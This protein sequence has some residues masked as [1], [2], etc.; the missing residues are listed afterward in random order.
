MTKL[1]LIISS[2]ILGGVV[3]AYTYILQ[4]PSPSSSPIKIPVF[5]QKEVIG[6]LPYWLL[7]RAQ[8]DYSQDITTL[9]YFALRTNSDGS[10]LKLSSANQ[11]EPGYH[12]LY[13]GKVDTFLQNAKTKGLKLSL[14]LDSGD[15][16]AIQG[17][18][19]TP[20]AN[21]KRLITDTL[22]I[23]QKY[24]FSDLNLDIEYTSQ[25]SPQMRSNFAEFIK[26][27]RALLPKEDTL[28]LEISTLDVIQNQLI[29]TKAIS[30]FADHIVLM[31]YDY[32][33]PDSFISGPIAPLN[34]AGT[35]NE[36]D[37]TT[38]IEEALQMAPSQKIILGIPL[39]GYEWETL[40][41]T[42]RSA[43]IPGSGVTASVKR[44]NDL[45]SSCS[46]CSAQFDNVNQESFVSY[47]NQDTNTTHMLFFPT[48]ASTKAKINFA[49]SKN[50][51]GLALWA[52]GY[53][54]GDLLNPLTSYK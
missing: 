9:T 35:V 43:T 30:P 48:A 54:G 33:T 3:L 25:A 52:L 42:P 22:P 51:G 28:T 19:A 46:T 34:G 8:K 37:V 17:L 15:Q 36:Y 21:A 27:V 44:V 29:D 26:N 18:V 50:L 24:G 23:M 38:A 7:N 41:T 39:Y 12:A 14:T 32:H 6:F 5:S 53:E 47:F 49:N 2:S 10:I 11:A 1:L 20:S 31:A 16:T 4:F 40:G 45:L 13:S